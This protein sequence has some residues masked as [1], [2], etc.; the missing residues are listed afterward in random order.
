MGSAPRADRTS[1]FQQY[2]FLVL[3]LCMVYLCHQAA[4]RIGVRCFCNSCMSCGK[5]LDFVL[6]ANIFANLLASVLNV[7]KY[8]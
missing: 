6:S 4:R 8:T 3:L 5:L 2:N 1:H 7:K